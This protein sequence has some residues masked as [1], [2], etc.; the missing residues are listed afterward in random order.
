MRALLDVG[1]AY[2]TMKMFFI[3]YRPAILSI[4]N[5]SVFDWYARMN[6]SSLGDPWNGGR[7]EFKTLY[8]AKVPIPDSSFNHDDLFEIMVK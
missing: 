7:L 6:F 5:S 2:G 4:L 8:M 3:P 1:K